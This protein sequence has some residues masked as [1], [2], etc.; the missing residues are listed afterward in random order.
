MTDGRAAARRRLGLALAAA[1]LLLIALWLT[2]GAATF[3]AL[4]LHL[5]A[6]VVFMLV[7][8]LLL[9]RRRATVALLGLIVI[10][11]GPPGGLLLFTL[12]PTGPAA[13]RDLDSRRDAAR[14]LPPASRARRIYRD[15]RQNRRPLLDGALPQGFSDVLDAGTMPERYRV[16][17]VIS[18]HYQP[19]ML[20]TLRLALASPAP[21]LRVQAAAVYAKLRGDFGEEAGRLLSG[22]S[23]GLSAQGARARIA[24]LD[25]VAASGFV[26][27]EVRARLRE[28]AEALRARAREDAAGET[29]LRA[30]AADDLAAPLSIQPGGAIGAAAMKGAG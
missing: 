25:R 28:G 1:D 23:E 16:I 8:L 4:G 14:R 10:L 29:E 18:R 20:A 12:E 22:P 21:V 13:G 17:S 2:G 30:E 5:A 6:T 9:R 24:A 19:E 15:I 27:D 7:S 26:D 3:P 11:L